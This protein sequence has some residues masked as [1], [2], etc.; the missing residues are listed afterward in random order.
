MTTEIVDTRQ[1][2]SNFWNDERKEL[3]RQMWAKD[4]SPQEFEMF[5]MVCALTRLDPFMKQIIPVI[6]SR[7]NKDTKQR[8]K[9]M[10]L[11]STIDAL[12]VVAER[13][14][15]YE[16]ASE[17][18]WC[19][20]DGIWKTPWTSKDM[21]VACRIEVYKK[22]SRLP[23]VG[24]VYYDALVQT[25]DGKPGDFWAGKKGVSQLE[26][27]AL[28]KALRRA[29]PHDIGKVYLHEEM[30]QA[31]TLVEKTIR[32]KN[33]TSEDFL[34]DLDPELGNRLAK[35]GF[36][37]EAKVKNLYAEAGSTL[38]GLTLHL[39]ASELASRLDDGLKDKM[40]VCGIRNVMEAR[41]K[42]V[43]IG[44]SVEAITKWV[45]EQIEG[46]KPKAIE[47]QAQVPLIQPPATEVL[48]PEP[49]KL[50][51]KDQPVIRRPKGRS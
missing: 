19:G 4:C 28:A 7:Y 8:E 31:E 6:R 29:F 21:P 48:K 46:T 20:E 22:D 5:M 39:E 47:E 40:R 50:A 36:D 33:E 27:C 38:E 51:P 30:D 3:A 41:R 9:F 12:C 15:K 25:Y 11:Q 17:P 45:D 35:A 23:T 34:R 32:E 42:I 1:Q 13:T 18:Q 24:I 44:V 49:A 16:G 2:F 14:G 43:E 10:T 37:N 26:K